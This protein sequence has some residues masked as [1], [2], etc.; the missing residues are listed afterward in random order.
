MSQALDKPLII[1]D[2]ASNSCTSASVGE[3]SNI[4]N[5]PNNAQQNAENKTQNNHEDSDGFRPGTSTVIVLEETISVEKSTHSQTRQHGNVCDNSNVRQNICISK[6]Y[7]DNVKINFKVT[8]VTSKID[9]HHQNKN[10]SI[11]KVKILLYT[12]CSKSYGSPRY[13]INV[14]K[15]V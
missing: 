12:V 2:I 8:V 10:H 5:V 13:F 14:E 7:V 3:W 6:S 15:N 9:H 11:Q 1:D 4:I